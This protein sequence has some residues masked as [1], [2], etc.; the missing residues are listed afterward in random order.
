MGQQRVLLALVEA[1]D[2]VDEE[3]RGAAA[4][5][6]PVARAGDRGSHLLD[7]AGGRRED[8]EA[9]ADRLRQQSR[10]RRLADAWRSP[11][12][13]RREPASFDH[14]TQRPSLS[15]Q[16][17]LAHELGEVTRP[18][19]GRQ[20]CVVGFASEGQALRPHVAAN[21]PIGA[22]HPAESSAGHARHDYHLGTVNR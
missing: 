6:E 17:F 10:Q 4:P 2:L 5:V 15:D 18:H 11:E 14:A 16:R 19:A 20:G 8:V 9:R 13:H 3:D 12:H 7:A 1:M 22:V 21:D